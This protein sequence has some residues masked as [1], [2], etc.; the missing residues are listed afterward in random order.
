MSFM[1]LSNTLL[2][3][4]PTEQDCL[5]AIPV[6]QDEY[7]QEE[8]YSGTGN[9]PNEINGLNGTCIVG[10]EANSVWYTFTVVESGALSFILTPD[11]PMNDYDWSL[12]NL[13][14]ATCDDIYDDPSLEVS[15]NSWGALFIEQGPTGI[16]TAEGGEGNSNGPGD[17]NGPPFNADLEV[18]EGETYVLCVQDWSGTDDGY[19][20]DF[21]PSIAS[22]YDETSPQ[23]TSAQLNCDFT[24]DVEFDEPLLCENLSYL[25]FQITAT[26][27]E[28][29]LPSDMVS[30]CDNDANFTSVFT[31]LFDDPITSLLGDDFILSVLETDNNVEDACGNLAEILDFDFP[32]VEGITFSPSSSPADCNLANGSIDFGSVEN[33]IGSITYEVDGEEQDN[34]LFEGL[35]SGDYTLTVTDEND[36]TISTM[37]TIDEIPMIGIDAG[38][39]DFTCDMNYSLSGAQDESYPLVW[40]TSDDVDILDHTS[41]NTD[42]VASSPGTY[43]FTLTV[44]QDGCDVTDNVSIT[45]SDVSLSMDLV[46]NECGDNCTGTAEVFAAGGT[47]PYTATWTGLN[48]F[49]GMSLAENI[50][51]GNYSV[52]MTDL[53]GCSNSMSFEITEPLQPVILSAAIINEDCIGY[54][55]GSLEVNALHAVS[56]SISGPQNMQ[57]DS[58]FTG[59]CHG[60]YEVWISSDYGCLASTIFNVGTHIP[61]DADFDVSPAVASIENPV[62]N[63]AN[64]TEGS[65]SLEWVIGSDE[66][67]EMDNIESF[68]YTFSEAVPGHYDITLIIT[69]E[70]G[71]ST[72]Q[73]QLVEIVSAFYVYIPNAFTPDGDGI[74]E[75]FQIQVRGH[76]NDKYDLSI[77]N[78]WGEVVY[79]S[80]DPEEVWQGERMDGNHYFSD[81]ETYVYRLKVKPEFEIEERVYTGNITIIR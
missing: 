30:E 51:A 21:S 62:F 76:E 13:T 65:N 28:V 64:E 35:P 48:G 36:C 63:I 81:T 17:L 72:A 50:C 54:C 22:I 7:Y 45:F 23:I 77:F 27:G 42:L 34:P 5:G 33:G 15:C 53:N 6:C 26:D 16:S 29:Y 2:G 31:L 55:N 73:S 56:Y 14:N 24:L 41:L 47:S 20:L 78:R 57:N 37:L 71:C 75:T 68:E 10:G 66:L 43:N 69:D 40:S 4:T 32:T 11:D 61:P 79:H 44:D 80:N 18:L 25:D 39:N 8:A 59:L 12:Y 70:E 52:Q 19:T 67:E 46:D 74:N 3:Q 60:A 9:F 38:E 58:L 49:D 1:A